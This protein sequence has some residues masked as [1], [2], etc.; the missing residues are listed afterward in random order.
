MRCPVN[1]AFVP[2][3]YYDL[4][5]SLILRNLLLRFDQL[6]TEYLEP[7][8]RCESQL[9]IEDTCSWTAEAQN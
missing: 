4:G 6:L 3:M 9:V 1:V 2:Y 8:D 5:Y 7:F